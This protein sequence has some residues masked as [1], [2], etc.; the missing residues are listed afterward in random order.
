MIDD[1]YYIDKTFELAVQGKGFVSPNPMVGCVIVREG[2]VL[3]YGYHRNYGGDHA[4]VD[5]IKSY[6][7][8]LR[9]GTAYVNLA[10]CCHTG[11]TGACTKA[12]IDAG[13]SR[14]VYSNEDPNPL[15]ADFSTKKLVGAGIE[16]VG[17]ILTDRGY[18]LNKKYFD[19]VKS[20]LPYVTAKMAV[21]LDG[22]IA[23]KS[24]E[25]KWI[26]G[27]SARD[28]VYELRRGY[29]AILV[30]S[31][32]VLQDNPNLGLHGKSGRDPLRMI[33][34]SDSRKFSNLSD[35]FVFRDDNYVFIESIA[36]LI[37]YCAE[38]NIS[39]VLV[40]GGAGVFTSFLRSGYLNDIYLF[41]GPK[42]LGNEH[43]SVVDE[44]ALP[45]LSD[46]YEFKISS[47]SSFG[48]SFLVK[49]DI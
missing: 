11:K 33:L 46:A 22:K 24:F 4:E 47:V 45:S 23:T 2:K 39:S 19:S 25:S 48:D 37:E 28:F 14:V 42:F 7:G 49:L 29:D 5:A 12:L 16:V 13:I 1:S 31:N 18:Q 30:G 20:K 36:H 17:G 26:T 21:T 8:S 27:E 35:L 34:C 15:V 3:S 40:E 6:S 32:T 10:P 41:Y 9:G 38:N 43:V 44:L